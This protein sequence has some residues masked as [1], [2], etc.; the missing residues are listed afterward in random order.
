M[1]DIVISVIVGVLSGAVAFLG[2]FLARKRNA[3]TENKE[4]L[5][6]PP[7]RT[8]K[9]YEELDRIDLDDVPDSELSEILDGATEER[10]A[11][12][13]SLRKP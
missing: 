3:N 4:K 11:R 8:E 6:S 5:P 9:I 13:R 10:E 7:S 1:I 2:I 12:L